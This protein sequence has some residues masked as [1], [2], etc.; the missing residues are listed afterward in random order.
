MFRIVALALIA[1]TS[2][3]AGSIQFRWTASDS[4][5]LI[6]NYQQWDVI[7]IEDGITVFENGYPDL[8]AVS[9]C[10]VLPQGTTITDIEVTDI[11][12]VS[13]GN[14]LSPVP[15]MLLP[16][17][18][19]VPDFP[20]YTE[21]CLDG[22]SGVFPESPIAGYKTGTKT[23]YRI[24]S[25]SFVPFRYNRQ[26]GEL[27]LITSADI[28]II[29][30]YDSNAPVYTLSESQIELAARG[31]STFVDNP[32]MLTEWAPME[33]P[34]AEDDVQVIVIGYRQHSDQLAELVSFHNGLEYSCDSITVQWILANVDG[35]D[36]QERIRNYIIDLYQ[37][38]G[39][40]FA[41]IA[42]DRG[43]TTRLSQL[44]FPYWTEA[45]NSTAD[46]YYS[47][48]DG[49]WD[50][51]GNH[52]YGEE[53]D[54][55]DYYSDIYVG[56]YPINVNEADAFNA[57]LDKVVQYNTASIAE[58]WQTRALLMG[59]CL[60]PMEPEGAWRFGSK[61]CDSLASFF[62]SDW[63]WNTVYEDTTGYHPN[64]QLE[65]FNQGTAISAYFAHGNQEG[66]YWYYP[67]PSYPPVMNTDTISQMTN[68]GK[69][70]WSIGY[71]SCTTGAIFGN[72]FAESL[73]ERDSGGAIVAVAC[74]NTSF[75][76][77]TDP[78]PAGWLSINFAHLLFDDSISSAGLTHGLSKDMFWANWNSFYAPR[79]AEWILQ[80][81]N[82][83]GDP[84]TI[85]IGAQEEIE[86]YSG[87]G[88]NISLGQNPVYSQLSLE[89]TLPEPAAVSIVLYDL[90]GRAVL[91]MEDQVSQAG[92][93]GVVL[94]TSELT[95]GTYFARVSTPL[96][97]SS[98]KLVVLR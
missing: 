83:Y 80:N 3:S 98:V 92:A 75:G 72:G 57:M 87:S 86:S 6:E 95:T 10:Y 97:N 59:A 22:M 44:D 66:F 84:C 36:Y 33:R 7:S 19:D 67:Q 4:D 50:G 30:Q 45:M 93:Y 9:R 71:L 35:Y 14:F 5:V 21:I 82:L 31:L 18:V 56:R 54:D 60:F 64:N 79:K 90:L 53:D 55:I 62:P 11:S 73:V 39:L 28:N 58:D 70:P 27:L 91:S 26:G 74:S 88:F 68:C 24:G 48:L 8:P 2:V 77:I 1:S 41:V 51:N 37:N 25:Y 94:D 96:H 85:F 12:T 81:A 65:L 42:G 69:L 40:L 46:L 78:G 52:L 23:G 34:D 38:K 43:A 76:G 15:V 47:D 63:E 61:Y 32:E 20:D 89:I 29:Y 16:L 13:L 17:S 49:T